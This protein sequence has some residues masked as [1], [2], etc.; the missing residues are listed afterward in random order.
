VLEKAVAARL[1]HHLRT[2]NLL[3]PLQSAYR[4]YH[5]TET[6][7]AKVHNDLALALDKKKACLL[8]LLDLSAAFDTIDHD[9]LLQRCASLFGITSTALAW[10]KCY[11]SNRSQRVLVGGCSSKAKSLKCGVP[12]GSILGPLLFIM[13][14]TPLGSLLQQQNTDYHLYA[15]DTQLYLKFEP[16]D[17]GAA[18]VHMENAIRM[19]H[20]WMSHNMLKLN[21]SKTEVLVIANKQHLES[22]R[23]ASLRVGGDDIKLTSTARNI[24]VTFDSTLSM[25]PHINSSA[26]SANYHLRNIGRVRKFLTKAATEQLVHSL[27]TCRLDYGNALL[28]NVPKCHL[29]KLQTVQNTAARIIT[30]T[31]KYEHIMPLLRSLHWLP[32]DA[33][34]KF[35]IC[36]LTYK[37]LHHQAPVY[38]EDMIKPYIPSRS[39]RSVSQNLLVI[40]PS[41]TKTYG[42]RAFSVAAPVLWNSLPLDLR[43]CPSLNAFKSHLKTFLFKLTYG[44]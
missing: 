1:K 28:V 27:V 34:I 5:S 25:I 26:R 2:N 36:L 29:S 41:K 24:G 18:A 6:A 23:D 14:T 9:F 31:T 11:L 19:V 16:A 39:L 44:L 32:I 13:Y 17:F 8:I 38:I 7:L 10:L 37:A 35:K 42:A 21:T 12:Q 22:F 33:R 30:G 4:Q 20:S 40:P 15:D 3:E 43:Q